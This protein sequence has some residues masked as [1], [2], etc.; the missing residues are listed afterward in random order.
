MR[1]QTD[2][3]DGSAVLFVLTAHIA[4][5]KVQLDIR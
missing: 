4:L 1:G 2:A 3:T 5:D